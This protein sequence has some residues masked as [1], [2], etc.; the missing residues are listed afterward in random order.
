M[1]HR[2]WQKTTGTPAGNHTSEDL[3]TRSIL[4]T[5]DAS[6]QMIAAHPAAGIVS[7]TYN[8][9]GQRIVKDSFGTGTGFLYDHKRLLHE[10]DELGQVTHTYTSSTTA[11]FGDLIGENG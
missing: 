8:A 9:D 10:T 1:R 2:V 6:G 7:F 11:E 3:L 4:Y 5:W